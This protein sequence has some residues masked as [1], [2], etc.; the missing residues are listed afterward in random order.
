MKNNLKIYQKN[1]TLEEIKEER[2]DLL[3]ALDSI[4]TTI[5]ALK[6]VGFYESSILALE[7]EKAEIE[8]VIEEIEE[9]IEE[10]E[11]EELQEYNAEMQ[12]MNYEFEGSRV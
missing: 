2:N 7:N 12:T 5:T 10:A 9:Y 4:D 8:A 1:S 6:Q 3:F 11:K